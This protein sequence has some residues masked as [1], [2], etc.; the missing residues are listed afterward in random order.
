M[1]SAQKRHIKKYLPNL[2]NEQIRLFTKVTTQIPLSEF[3]DWLLKEMEEELIDAARNVT[4]ERDAILEE[5]V[6][7]GVAKQV[8]S[9]T[10]SVQKRL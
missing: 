1:T 6:L 7:Q 5:R 9:K 10:K 3:P 8:M 2:S 4:R